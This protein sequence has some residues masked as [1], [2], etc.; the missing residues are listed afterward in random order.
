MGSPAAPADV[1]YTE[2]EL[3]IDMA[4]FHKQSMKAVQRLPQHARYGAAPSP[5]AR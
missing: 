2:D 1:T 3:G 5:R 4:Q